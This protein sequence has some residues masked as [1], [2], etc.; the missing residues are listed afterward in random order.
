MQVLAGRPASLPAAAV[1]VRGGVDGSAAI[2]PAALA[3]WVAARLPPAAVPRAEHVVMVESL[4]RNALGKVDKPGLRRSVFG[5][6][7]QP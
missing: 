7:Q 6:Q 3:A 2:T 1:V 4:P 5:E